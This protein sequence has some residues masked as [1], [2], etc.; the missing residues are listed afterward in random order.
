LQGVRQLVRE[1]R[2]LLFDVQPVQQIHGFGFNVV[3]SRNLL[4]Q[5]RHEKFGEFKI[6][7][8]QSKL[9]EHLRRPLQTFGIL[10]VLE[11]FF[12]ILL[13]LVAFG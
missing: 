7:R 10:I 2:L 9:L 8:Y 1:D 6:A 11:A 3:I 5:H 13:H 4:P 12:D